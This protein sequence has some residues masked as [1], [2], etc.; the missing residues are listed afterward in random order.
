MKKKLSFKLFDGLKIYC[1]D[2]Q[3]WKSICEFS[4]KGIGKKQQM[5]LTYLLLNHKRRISS[6]ELIER[7]WGEKGDA[8]ENSLKNM[9]HKTRKLLQLIFPECKELIV[10]QVG[11]YEW[12]R[13]YEIETDVELFEEYYKNLDYLTEE[14][15]IKAL[16][17]LELYSGNILREYRLIGSII[18]ILIIKLSISISANL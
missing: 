4:E 2:E 3:C 11:A 14:G 13:G 1:E 12:S 7:F 8:P 10:T 18:L 15:Q 17:A 9:L 5:F 16:A 6:A